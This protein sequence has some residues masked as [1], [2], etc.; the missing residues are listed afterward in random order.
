MLVACRQAGL[1]ALEATM[2][3]S[4]REGNSGPAKRTTFAVRRG[5]ST[6]WPSPPAVWWVINDRVAPGLRAVE[7]DAP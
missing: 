1:S 7:E 4:V 6:R 2:M 5:R 3:A